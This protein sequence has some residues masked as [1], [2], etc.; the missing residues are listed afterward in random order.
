[1]GHQLTIYTLL[2]AMEKLAAILQGQALPYVIC[3]ADL[4]ANNVLRDPANHMFVIDWDDVMLSQKSE[5][6]SLSG[7][8]PQMM[9]QHVRNPLLFSGVRTDRD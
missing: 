7:K 5:I 9:A 3:H 8:Y 6:S 4:H 2:T 1:M